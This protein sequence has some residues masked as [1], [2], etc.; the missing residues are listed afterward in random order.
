MLSDLNVMEI[1]SRLIALILIIILSPL[2]LIILLTSF[3][4][5]GSP[6][7]FKQIRVGKNFKHFNILKFRTLKN[8]QTEPN[9]FSK[10]TNLKT[11]KWGLF[12]RKAKLD[13]LPQLFN[14]IKGDM[15]FIGPRPEIPQYVNPETFDFLK[16]IKP[17]LSGYSSILF[18]NEAEILSMIDQEDPYDDILKIK[19]AL[20]K[21]YLGKKGFFEDLK[22]VFLTIFSLIIPKRTGHYILLKLLKIKDKGPFEALIHKPTNYNSHA[23]KSSTN[24][25]LISLSDKNLIYPKSLL[26][27]LKIKSKIDI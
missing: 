11:S 16:K 5:Q 3:I 19:I 14:I 13:E 26:D 21:Y 9:L 18:R 17:G 15:R 7:I 20:D 27:T 2:F 4:F 12:L 24:L 10:K 8:I 6:I 23:S 22:L 1:F 25:S